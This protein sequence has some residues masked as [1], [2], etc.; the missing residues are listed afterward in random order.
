MQVPGEEHRPG[1][2]V[3]ARVDLAGDAHHYHHASYRRE[4]HYTH[5]RLNIYPD[6]GIARL[7]V[8]GLIKPDWGRYRGRM[9][10]ARSCWPCKT[11]AR[12]IGLQQ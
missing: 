9:H 2:E 4:S 12:R 1:T 10:L 5:L 3:L 6:G 11:A 8:Y 7:R